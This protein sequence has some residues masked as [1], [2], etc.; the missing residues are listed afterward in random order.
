VTES[1]N[2]TATTTP[3]KW[4]LRLV[5]VLTIIIVI[6]AVAASLYFRDHLQELE[7]YG[8]AAVFLVGLVSNATLILPVP[9][10]AVSSLMGGVFNPWIVGIVGGIGQALGEL[11]GY[12]VG[13][14]GQELVDENPTYDRLTS[15]MRRHGMLTV[16]VL[17]VTPNPIF[18]LGGIAAGALRYP[19][20][21]FLI[22][23]AAGK[24]V[25]NI[26]FALFGYYGIDTIYQL[27]Q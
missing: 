10:L 18:D 14:S 8:Y 15:W 24:I 6:G 20:W 22:S 11:S 23:C 7:G 16:F 17:S 19:I 1:P 21:K 5:Q 2:D 4:R 13:Y 25:K 27:F 9:G 12:M 26:A 3:K